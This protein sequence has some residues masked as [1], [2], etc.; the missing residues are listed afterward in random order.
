ML[1]QIRYFQAVVRLNSFSEA[2]AECHI[3]QSAVSQQVQA[4]ERELGF[5]LLERKNR[6]FTFT[7]AGEHFYRKSL[8]LIADWERLCRE[9]EV[10]ARQDDAQ[11]SLGYLKSYGGQELHLAVA[12]FSARHPEMDLHIIPGNTLE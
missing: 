7:L 11:L 8:L 5:P 9:T 3:S 4:L 1:Q 12:D 2:A 10:I 6:K